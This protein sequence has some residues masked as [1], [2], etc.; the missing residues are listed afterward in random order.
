[1][2]FSRFDSL[3]RAISTLTTR[4]S[5]LGLLTGGLAAGG[6]FF[7]DGDDAVAGRRRRRRA[8]HRRHKARR[9][10]SRRNGKC[11]PRPVAA[12]CA[13]RC[14]LV[15]NRK[16]CGRTVDC[17]PCGADPGCPECQANQLCRNGACR[18]CTVSCASNQSPEECGAALTAALADDTL[19]EITICPG[20]YVGNFVIS[21]GVTL[22]GAGQGDNP[23][24]N[25]ILSADQTGRVLW[26]ATDAGPVTLENLRITGGMLTD[27]YGA[28]ILS[29]GAG[30]TMTNCTV[31]GNEGSN[32]EGVGIWSLA[33]LQMTNCEVSDNVCTNGNEALAGGIFAQGATTL[34]DCLV[35]GNT[36]TG[37][38]GGIVVAG[39]TSLLGQTLVSNNTAA[40][41]GGILVAAEASLTVA[42]ACRVTHNTATS[43]W[44]GI[45]N[46][47]DG[48]V[49][50][51]GPSPESIVVENCPDN[52]L[53]VPGC[54]EDHHGD[55]SG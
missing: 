11:S 5:I 32:V 49:T 53:N 50:L 21:R 46:N 6:L 17:G 10:R 34:S 45:A 51:Q 42:P 30:L 4:R 14:G 31:T 18:D 54:T 23:A 20:T 43:L 48:T 7:A 8:R 33:T 39:T 52:C 35:T 25:T 15:T 37:E 27:D 47:V 13:G 44:G 1:M 12:I 2:D 3:T 36:T 55:C 16:T 29:Q 24:A 38:G 41:G 40:A 22:I 26:L 19:S 28:G 9:S